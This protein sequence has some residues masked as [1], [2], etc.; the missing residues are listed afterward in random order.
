L[1]RLP[2]RAQGRYRRDNIALRA[3]DFGGARMLRSLHHLRGKYVRPL[4]VSIHR[5]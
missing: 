3:G 1:Q 4:P 2:L 5:A